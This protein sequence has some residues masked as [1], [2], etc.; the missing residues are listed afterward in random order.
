MKVLIYLFVFIAPC[1]IANASTLPDSISKRDSTA[2]A[3]SVALADSATLVK[4]Q[5]DSITKK[6]VTL[7]VEACEISAEKPLEALKNYRAA[8]KINK[9]KDEVW[10][11]NIRLAMGKILAKAKSKDALP[12]LLKADL[13]FKK[14]ANLVGR[15]N[16]LT[17]IAAIYESKGQFT[18]AL[19]NYNELYKI[20]LKVGEAVLAG[21]IAS[22][23]TDI[24][25]KSKNYTEAFKYADMAKTAYYKVCRKDSLGSIY[26]KIAYIKKNTNSPKL[27]EYYILNQAL[28]YYRASND[29]EGRLK[30]FDFLGHLY[31]DQKRYS[32]AKWFYLQANNQSRLANDTASIITSLINLGV[33]K[34]LI[35]DLVLAKQDIAEAELIIQNDSTYAPL[36]EK[37][38]IK[39]SW[40]F[41][42]LTAKTLAS[43]T[44]LKSPAV[45]TPV[46]KAATATKPT[47]AAVLTDAEKKEKEIIP[48]KKIN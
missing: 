47:S 8:L 18:E 46:K 44:K 21:N 25:L 34:I 32:E 38:K 29:L 3:D 48:A 35:G 33:I 2:L 41:K 24:F 19:K 4:N 43:N 15:A 42:K 17:E 7:L 5:A 6:V 10:E 12:Q 11:A 31:Q 1:L 27:A 36:M 22:H 45:K 20:Q 30:S 14:K 26:Y 23:L 16:T 28:S 13:L 39:H 9:V 37:A 40:L